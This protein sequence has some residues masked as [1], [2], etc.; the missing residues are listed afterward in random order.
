MHSVLKDVPLWLDEGLAEFFELPADAS[1]VNPKHLEELRK[2]PFTPDMVR[3]EQM[4]QVA[5]MTP[6][7]YRESWA[8]VHFMLRGSPPGRQ[9]LL[10]Y[11]QQLR[12]TPNAGSLAVRLTPAVPQAPEALLAHLKQVQRSQFAGQ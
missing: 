4:T 11:L 1:G 5:Q 6:A 10:A 8:W 7:E 9:V 12:S 2:N 3:L